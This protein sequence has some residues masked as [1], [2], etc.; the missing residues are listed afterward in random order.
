MTAQEKAAEVLVTPET[1][2]KNHDCTDHFTCPA[3]NERILLQVKG[4][5]LYFMAKRI[6]LC[7]AAIRVRG[8]QVAQQDDGSHDVARQ[9]RREHLPD[10]LAMEAW[11][12][13]GQPRLQRVAS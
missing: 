10:F 7:T 9:G 12:T 2:R 5:P 1:A 8:Y 3:A 11:P 6:E 4:S 13:A